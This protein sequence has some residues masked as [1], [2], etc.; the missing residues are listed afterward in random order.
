MRRLDKFK[1]S[2]NIILKIYENFFMKNDEIQ[3]L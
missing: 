1:K 3:A 2:A